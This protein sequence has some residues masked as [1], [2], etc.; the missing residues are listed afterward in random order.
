MLHVDAIPIC[1]FLKSS[2]LKP[3]ACSMARLGA[4]SMPSTTNEEKVRVDLSPELAI[5]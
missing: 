4:R 5:F 1:G 2:I 3:T